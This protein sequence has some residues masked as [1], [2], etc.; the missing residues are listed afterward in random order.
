[1]KVVALTCPQCGGSQDVSDDQRIL[2]CRYCRTTLHVERSVSGEIERLLIEAQEENSELLMEN[3][4][5]EVQNALHRLEKAWEE[6]RERYLIHTKNGTFEP[7]VA[8]GWVLVLLGVC[9]LVIALVVTEA[10]VMIPGLMIGLYGMWIRSR[11]RHFEEARDAYVGRH[12]ELTG[13]LAR[14]EHAAN[15]HPSYED[16]RKRRER[17]DRMSYPAADA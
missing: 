8:L 6:R 12:T 10:L 2:E 5:L 9:V 1:M 13:Q 4:M 17:L 11:G 3:R 7:K 15:R 16:T 14:L